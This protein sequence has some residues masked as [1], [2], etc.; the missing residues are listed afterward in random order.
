MNRSD[1]Y[2]RVVKL[3]FSRRKPSS[4]HFLHRRIRGRR[5]SHL[6]QES[7]LS[8]SSKPSFLPRSAPHSSRSGSLIT[9]LPFLPP[10]PRLFFSRRLTPSLPL[11]S[12][13][14]RSLPNPSS[15]LILPSSK[16]KPP[17]GTPLPHKTLPPP[18]APPLSQKLSSTPPLLPIRPTV[19]IKLVP[20]LRLPSRVHCHRASGA[21]LLHG[22][23]T[24]TKIPR[25]PIRM[26][27]TSTYRVLLGRQADPP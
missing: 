9:G 21:S 5:T 23:R 17:H 4:L 1:T 27:M 13:L 2:L 11:P 16:T 20:P 14:R 22:V 3:A 6:P 19:H 24:S 15:R 10:F 8:P 25:P 26:R 12:L 18:R 7:H